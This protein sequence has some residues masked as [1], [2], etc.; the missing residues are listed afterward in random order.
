MSL[1][2]CPYRG[3]DRLMEGECMQDKCAWFDS[4]LRKCAVL[5]I[6]ES[7]T[8][9]EDILKRKKVLEK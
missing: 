9:L 3:A 4:G 7:L 8:A 5:R 6:S 2:I 1:P